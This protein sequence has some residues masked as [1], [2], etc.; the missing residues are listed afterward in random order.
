MKVYNTRQ[1][2]NIKYDGFETKGILIC[3]NEKDNVIKTLKQ[4]LENSTMYDANKSES[5]NEND[6]TLQWVNYGVPDFVNL[7]WV[8]PEFKNINKRVFI[9]SENIVTVP[10][11]TFNLI[12]NTKDLK[13][14]VVVN[15]IQEFC[16]EKTTY[17][18]KINGLY[19]QFN[20]IIDFGVIVVFCF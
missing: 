4:Y 19:K 3:N 1:F 8:T 5:D 15:H 12:N 18:V 16:N 7:K 6:I 11:I 9:N 13:Y 17:D 2:P 20:N 14:A 10:R